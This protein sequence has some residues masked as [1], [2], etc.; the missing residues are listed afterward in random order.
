M[1]GHSKFSNIVHRKT[2]QD[3]KRSKIFSKLAR[4]ISVAA[5]SG[6]DP[7]DNSGLRGAIAAARAQNMP[8]E[9]IERAIKS[10]AARDAETFDEIRYEGFG[11]GG[12][13]M[14]VE[15]LTDNRNRTASEVRSSFQKYGGNLGEPGTV[16][17]MFQRVGLIFY[18]ESVADAEAVFEAAL[19]AGADDCETLD[20]GHEILCGAENLNAVRDALETSLGEPAEFARQIWRPQSSVALGGDNAASLFKLI[21]LLEDNEDIQRVYANHE[22]DDAVLEQLGV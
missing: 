2:A 13:A 11:P 6:P 21:E 8:K 9:R 12:V 5:K 1:A 22:V 15:A 14:I 20:E 16:A 3:A 19:E 10:S 17:H 18:P 7:E 4:E